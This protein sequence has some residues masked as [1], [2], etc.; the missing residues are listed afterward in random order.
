[1]NGIVT[2]E[3]EVRGDTLILRMT[4]R[5]DAIS[6]PPAES[7]VVGYI[8]GGRNKLLIDMG[9][10]DYLSSAGMRML[11]S[12]AKKI[13]AHTG[14]FVLVAVTPNVMDILRMSG[15]DRIL[16]IAQNEEEGLK[17]L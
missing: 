15:F 7:K 5:L 11:L 17:K 6:S 14:K 10:I 1:M 2:I 16:E 12:V 8:N 13:K 4:G 9:G 3:E